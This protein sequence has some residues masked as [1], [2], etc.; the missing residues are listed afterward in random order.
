ML[1]QQSTAQNSVSKAI[2]YTRQTTTTVQIDSQHV[3]DD[4]AYSGDR[5]YT[6]GCSRSRAERFRAAQF[7]AA[8]SRAARFS[9][10]IDAELSRY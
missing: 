3:E 9:A 1:K 4:L 2:R 6:P 7:R 8:Q 5:L 10:A